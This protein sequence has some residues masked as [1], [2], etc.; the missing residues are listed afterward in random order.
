VVLTALVI[1]TFITVVVVSARSR[2]RAPGSPDLLLIAAN[3]T[4][5][6]PFSRSILVAPVAISDSASAMTA[7]LIQQVPVRTD[8]G[9]R[10]VSGKLPGLYGTAGETNPCDAVTL[11]NDL[12]REPAIARVWGL[13]LGITPQQIPHYLNTL[14]PVILLADTWVTAHT[15][16]DGITEQYQAVLQKGNGVLVDPLGVPRVHC[17]GGSP[18]IPPDAAAFGSFR[19]VGERWADFDPLRIV[20]INYGAADPPPTRS[21]LTLVDIG[22]GQRVIRPSGNTIDPPGTAVPLPDPA[23]MNVPPSNREEET[24][25]H[26]P[27]P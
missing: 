4:T 11:A 26:K 20:A 7:E 23:A 9:V 10:V 25:E 6:D 12:D 1:V 14:T 16:V 27:Q 24:D 13:A 3:A 15:L 8:R 17:A 21:A 18:L 2:D 22:T 5:T 19:L